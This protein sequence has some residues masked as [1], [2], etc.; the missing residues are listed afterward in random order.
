V[1][2]ALSLK[3]RNIVEVD[4]LRLKTEAYDTLNEEAIFLQLQYQLAIDYQDEL[5]AKYQL[6]AETNLSIITQFNELKAQFEAQEAKS[7]AR[8]EAQ[9]AK[10]EARFEAQE[11]KSEAQEAKFEEHKKEASTRMKTIAAAIAVA[12]SLCQENAA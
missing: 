12:A 2:V 5:Q 1:Q 9:E 4:K 8:F 6:Q 7:E 3:A 10:S 11:A